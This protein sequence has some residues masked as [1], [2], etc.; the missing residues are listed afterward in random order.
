[1]IPQTTSRLEIVVSVDL[2]KETDISFDIEFCWLE[3]GEEAIVS[4]ISQ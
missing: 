1:M 3:V 4:V 2:G